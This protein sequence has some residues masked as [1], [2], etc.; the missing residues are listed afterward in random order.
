MSASFYF[1]THVHINKD[2]VTLF[3]SSRQDILEVGIY[4]TSKKTSQPKPPQHIIVPPLQ[5]SLEI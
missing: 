5:V 2:C 3:Q 1:F 4:A